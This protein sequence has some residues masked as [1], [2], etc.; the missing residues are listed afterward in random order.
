M[1]RRKAQTKPFGY[2][3]YKRAKDQRPFKGFWQSTDFEELKA[4]ASDENASDSDESETTDHDAVADA[5]PFRDIMDKIVESTASQRNLIAI[6]PAAQVLFSRAV[7]EEEVFKPL[8]DNCPVVEET[9]T[10]AIHGLDEATYF[11]GLKRRKKLDQLDSGL[12]HLPGAVLMSVIAAFESILADSIKTM[13]RQKSDRYAAGDKVIKVSDV[14]SKH[15]FE[16]VVE[17]IISEEL[18]SFFRSSHADQVKFIDTNFGV[19]IREKWKRYPDFIEIFERRN[20]V[21]HGESKFT[22]RYADICIANGHKGSE[23]IVGQEIR[24]SHKYL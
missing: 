15:S 22:A 10:Y 5:D 17:Q 4:W 12:K 11:D 8:R 6:A 2:F 13:L 18:Y 21:A 23:K 19:S 20:L 7:A 24:L 9:E 16:E 14:L 1:A 3:A